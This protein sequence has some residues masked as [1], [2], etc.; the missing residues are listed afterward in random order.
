MLEDMELD[1]GVSCGIIQLPDLVEFDFGI[2]LSSLP[3]SLPIAA[4]ST[5]CV[6][7]LRGL[8][9]LNLQAVA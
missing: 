4:R 7:L 6:Y 3:V 5:A 1:E 2:D 9:G 8:V